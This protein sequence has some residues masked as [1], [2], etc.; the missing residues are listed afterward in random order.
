MEVS[1]SR[2]LLEGPAFGLVIL[3]YFIVAVAVVHLFIDFCPYFFLSDCFFV[4]GLSFI[5]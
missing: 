4:F 2:N 3:I 5:L 1:T